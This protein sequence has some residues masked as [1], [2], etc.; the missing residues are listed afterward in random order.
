LKRRALVR[1]N[2]A[3]AWSLSRNKEGAHRTV[4]ARDLSPEVLRSKKKKHRMM[5]VFDHGREP[6]V[7]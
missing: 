7:S 4:V 3:S 2:D 6:C 1:R 5:A